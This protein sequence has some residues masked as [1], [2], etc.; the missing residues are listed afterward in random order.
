MAVFK[1]SEQIIILAVNVATNLNEGKETR[2][3]VNH[4]IKNTGKRRKAG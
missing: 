1:E 3:Q 4:I 2:R